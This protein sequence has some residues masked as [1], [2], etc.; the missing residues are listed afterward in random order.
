MAVNMT[1][2][3]QTQLKSDP[4]LARSADEE[5]WT[6]L[7]QLALAGAATHV[8]LLLKHGAD[9]NARTNHGMTALQLAKSLDWKNV[10][11]VLARHS[12]QF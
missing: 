6:F 12:K 9:P 2:S 4:E 11:A 3:L 10:I 1:E 5:G 8:D 7:H